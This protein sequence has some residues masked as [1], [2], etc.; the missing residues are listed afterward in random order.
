MTDH[1]AISLALLI[2]TTFVGLPAI[3]SEIM[4]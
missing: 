3:L 4:T 2:L 1:E